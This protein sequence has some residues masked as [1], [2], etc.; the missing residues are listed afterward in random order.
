[1][2]AARATGSLPGAEV[3]GSWPVEGDDVFNAEK[4]ANKKKARHRR[5][6]S[7]NPNL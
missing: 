2:S 5:A 3:E 1:M 6:L 7:K 4:P